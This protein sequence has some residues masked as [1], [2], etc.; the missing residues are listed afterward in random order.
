MPAIMRAKR[1]ISRRNRRDRDSR[2]HRRSRLFE[3]LE[4]RQ[5]MA[6]DFFV[7]AVGRDVELQMAV[8][9]EVPYLQVVDADSQVEIARSRVDEIDKKVHITSDSLLVDSD[10]LLDGNTLEV[11]ANLIQL[12]QGSIT[13]A[14]LDETGNSE[15]DSGDVHFTAREILI[16]PG[17][18]VNS[19][20]F[21]TGNFAPGDISLAVTDQPQ[22][23]ESIFNDTFLPALYTTR[24]AKIDIQ[25]ATI[26][27]GEVTITADGVTNT[28]WDDVGGFAEGIADQLL[29]ELQAIPQ[30]KI[31]TISP[32]SGQAKIHDASAQ[33]TLNDAT[34]TSSGSVTIGSTAMADSSLNAVAING[35]QS[36]G[37]PVL[38]S[39]GFSKSDATATVDVLGASKITAPGSI[40]ITTDATS[41]A[42]VTSR[43]DGNSRASGDSV[44]AAFN[45]ALAMTSETSKILVDSAARI[46][47][48]AEVV[49][50][51]AHAAVTNKVTATTA[52][53]QDG[54]GGLS[55]AIGIDNAD[56]LAEVR[57][58]VEGGS[59]V[60]GDGSGR[61]IRFSGAHVD[62]DSNQVTF[63]QVPASQPLRIGER[64]VFQ[65]DPAHD[66]GLIDGR[67]YIV[68][69]VSEPSQPVDGFVSQTARLVSAASVDL[70]NRQVPADSEHRLT[71]LS[72]IMFDADDVFSDP[73]T[74]DGVIRLPSLPA[75][76]TELTYLGGS[77]QAADEDEDPQ[78][79][80]IAGLVQNQAYEI[81]RVEGGIKLWLP[82][83]ADLLDFSAP[84]GGTHG[85]YYADNVQAFLPSAAVDNDRNTIRLPDGHG[86]RS[87]DLVFY[88]TDP[89]TTISRTI[90]K[91]NAD[92]SPAL[93]LGTVELPDAPIGGLADNMGYRVVIDDHAPNLIRLAT[94]KIG[95]LSA[96]VVDLQ[97]VQLGDFAFARESLAEGVSITASLTATNTATAG[98]ELSDEQQPW[99]AVAVGAATGEV[100]KLVA[101]GLGLI[102][103]LRSQLGADGK[104]VQQAKEDTGTSANTKDGID[105]AGTISV[106]YFDHDVKA[107]IA[108][109]ARITSQGDLTVAA[110][111][112]QQTTLG[113]AA[114][115][116]RNGT[117]DTSGSD[118]NDRDTEIGAAVGVGIYQNDAQAIIGGGAVTDARG[119]TS[120]TSHVDYPMLM[121]QVGDAV[122]PV[123][124]LDRFG[125]AG[126]EALMDG[127]LGL[128]QLLNVHAVAMAG[129][130][131]DARALG[132]AVVMTDYT[133]NVV[134]S[135]GEGARVNAG[136]IFS[137]E[138]Q[139]VL[140]DAR[141]TAMLI[142]AGQMA[143]INLSIPGFA[144][145]Y[146]DDPAAD[147]SKSFQEFVNEVV[148]PFGVSGEKAAG[149][150][151]LLTLA[152]NT[153]TA[154]IATGAVIGP[155]PQSVDV[156]AVSDFH[157][158]AIV[159]TG[160][161]STDF[162]FSASIAAA[163]ITSRTVARILDGAIVTAD[164][165]N[166]QAEDI[167]D[168][169]NIVGSYTKGRQ[170]GIGTSV[171]VNVIDQHA[172]AF[173]GRENVESVG[174]V[175]E[176]PTIR[177]AGPIDV[178]ATVDGD[179]FSLVMAGAV[180]GLGNASTSTDS[181]QT[182]AIALSVP[183][184]INDVTTS[185]LA[186]IDSQSVLAGDSTS[187]DPADLAVNAESLLDLRAIVIGA[188]FALQT[189]SGAANG[190]KL[191]LAGAGAVAI[192]TVGQN[193]A[194]YIT[195]SEVLQVGVGDVLLTAV[196]R[197][198]IHADAGGFG[199]AAARGNQGS[200]PS[201]GVSVAINDVSNDVSANVDRATVTTTLGDVLIGAESGITLEALSIAGAVSARAGQAGTNGSFGG[202]G[203][204]SQ[205]AVL[206]N[207]TAKVNSSQINAGQ[208]DLELRS[209][210]SRQIVAD[211]GG[212]GIGVAVG[213]GTTLAGTVGV[214]IA[215]NEIASSTKALLEASQVDADHEVLVLA[216]ADAATIKALSIAA[217]AG[218]GVT[219]RLGGT[220][221]GAGAGANNVMAT[222]IEALIQGGSVSAGDGVELQARDD[223]TID[224]FAVGASLG[225]TFASGPGG[226]VV[227][228]LSIA[229]TK[230]KT[231]SWPMCLTLS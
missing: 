26:A 6:A 169:I 190:D 123:T 211:A 92:N 93:S 222:T 48:A 138:T 17:S 14:D 149:G 18:I 21:G 47:S 183:V 65:A 202:A 122:N 16:G 168:R 28:R 106:A 109:T 74:G 22:V 95:A 39:T 150:I 24:T 174:V 218:V 130:Q 34:V 193:I 42:L 97:E 141:L 35:T 117:G 108:P 87:G 63:D 172:A 83:T 189:S 89:R 53:F 107:Y 177:I 185:V 212:F 58:A 4:P 192:N 99:P 78:A 224:A 120:V 214:G 128:S 139:G 152:D 111:I 135:I 94:S 197:S 114:E 124:T 178:R 112:T 179:L 66:I 133:N 30:I 36:D 175:P 137:G 15:A 71:R 206:A 217:T 118:A 198:S 43:A 126:F 1:R 23:S 171:G 210:D 67:T 61:L 207:T 162:G 143:A 194:A 220:L 7:D 45:L 161:G 132:A 187:S 146:M 27:G 176:Q 52:V 62:A 230:S 144:E 155:G 203:A 10:L 147:R 70:D 60:Q 216:S 46:E 140:V 125:V 13:T 201:F 148:N 119:Q 228:G 142:E 91:L 49:Q 157:N 29:A 55:A 86:L 158:V 8:F 44:E 215:L 90:T 226:S 219:T 134:A 75:D 50:I 182:G 167:L 80:G 98:V 116:T 85:F 12:V 115:A 105:L 68:H 25:D 77:I 31:S 79:V 72:S 227:I 37:S 38:I 32:L 84:G 159:Q 225:G 54:S 151:M 121:D 195:D 154:E 57:G 191:D 199:I 113:S 88:G 213:K 20:V 204:A 145:A 165:L 136:G 223:S 196:D 11:Q 82:G 104:A 56:V 19:T 5:M 59:A 101:S 129:S 188:S 200:A 69:E 221:S 153:T 163:D 181:K 209:V 102:D 33:I 51:D 103:Q 231:L 76:V 156:S 9:E 164:T 131:Q 170:L 229:P 184:A 208:G 173:V 127:S 81:Q 2:R 205:N 180:Q 3:P 64:V 40:I 186:Y 73:D 100:D 96:T 41:T 160:T 166:V 110:G